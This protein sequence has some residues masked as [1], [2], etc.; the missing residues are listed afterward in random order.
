MEDLVNTCRARLPHLLRLLPLPTLKS[1]VMV[2]FLNDAPHPEIPKRLVEVEVEVVEVV[3]V[4][5]VG[6][7][8]EGGGG[9]G[10]GSRR[11][12]ARSESHYP[13]PM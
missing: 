4:V 10:G 12:A 5:V 13:K 11:N 9:G 1:W 2:M 7:G 6:G 3:E 8:S